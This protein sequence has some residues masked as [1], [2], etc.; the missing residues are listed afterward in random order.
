[1]SDKNALRGSVRVKAFHVPGIL[2]NENTGVPTCTPLYCCLNQA[3]TGKWNGTKLDCSW[4]RPMS[5]I[6][7]TIYWL[8]GGSLPLRPYKGRACCTQRKRSSRG[9]KRGKIPI[10]SYQN[11]W[12]VLYILIRP[13]ASIIASAHWLYRYLHRI[14]TQS[15]LHRDI[16]LLYVSK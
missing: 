8:G 7:I 5:F 12:Y 4:K 14:V 13:R 15:Y 16:A 9:T 6:I 2:S 3:L 10:L 1:M 11:H